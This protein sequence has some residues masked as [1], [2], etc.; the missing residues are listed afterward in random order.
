MNMTNRNDLILQLMVLA[1]LVLFSFSAHAQR[2]NWVTQASG[3]SFDEVWSMGLAPNGDLHILGTFSDSVNFSGQEV[4]SYGNY[5]IF[6]ARYNSKGKV[7][8]SNGNGGFDI[9]DG[10]SIVVDNKGNYYFAG[11]FSTEAIVAGELID[12]I[13]PS[14][15]DMFV[16][17]VDKLGSLVWVKVFGSPTY[18]EGA[19]YVAVDSLGS[20]YV[21]GGVGGTGQFGEKRYT[22][23]GKLDAF[24][25]KLSANGDFV[26]VQ[27]SGSTDNDECTAISVSANGDRI[28]ASGTFI[29]QVNFGGIITIESYVNKADFFVRGF[30]A[31]GSTLWVKRIGY[32]GTD[33]HINSTT[34]FDGKLLLTGAM[35]EVTTFDTRTLTSNG[36]NASDFFVCRMAKDGNIELLKN[37]GGTFEDVGLS[38]AADAKGNIF[39]GGYYDSTTTVSEIIEQSNGGRDGFVTRIM[40]DG[41][42]D[43]L[44]SCG[45]PYDDEIRA[46]VIDPK[47]VPFVCGVFDTWALFEDLKITGNRFSDVFVAALD[48]GP[49]TSLKP[50]IGQLDICEGQDS[51]VQSRFGY[52]AYEWYV[53]GTKDPTVPSYTYR[54][55]KLVKGTYKVYCR[56]TGFDD[57]IKNTDTITINVRLGLPVPTI[58]RV[59]DELR[60][61]VDGKIY[62]WYREG[63]K[64]NG[65]MSQTLAISGEG[66]YRVRISDSTGC[67]RW[68]ENFLVGTTSVFGDEAGAIITLYPNPT[69]GQVTIAGASGAEITVTD[70]L[71]RVI[72]RLQNASDVQLV[73]IDGANG[74]YAVTL[75]SGNAVRTMLITK[76]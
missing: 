19:P 8:T 53:N 1:L 68:S 64:I 72:A 38:I 69:Q 42:V 70:M 48:C 41:S 30:N 61:S 73:T 11:A 17:K 36:S 20:V 13:D 37:Y 44:R 26:W 15:T 29:G 21:A 54:T 58:T 14:S 25:A 56:V 22:S 67:D 47:N 63:V 50:R 23:V 28:Y 74:T 5:D 2:W 49:Y 46:V 71:G 33:R 45:G 60:C 39:I 32:S 51:L 31:N 75:R 62:E 24:V 16:A 65:A 4:K 27:G 66:N 55:G 40:A 10:Q 3:P 9:D 7:L 12:A 76:Q 35:S 43:W 52:P 57:C 6:T 18:D 59:G 34:T